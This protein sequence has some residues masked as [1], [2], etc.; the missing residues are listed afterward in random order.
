MTTADVL[1][2]VRA[3]RRG[4]ADRGPAVGVRGHQGGRPAG[5]G[6]PDRAHHFRA[7]AAGHDARGR[8]PGAAPGR[9]AL[10]PDRSQ[11][12]GQGRGGRHP[13]ARRHGGGSRDPRGRLAV[14][15]GDAADAADVALRLGAG[16]PAGRL[17]GARRVRARPAAAGRPEALGPAHRRSGARRRR[18]LRTRSRSGARTDAAAATPDAAR[19]APRAWW[20]RL[21]RSLRLRLRRSGSFDSGRAPA[22]APAVGDT[23]AGARRRRSRPQL[24]RR[25]PC[26]RRPRSR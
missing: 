13:A 6:A 22:P 4:R 7:E 18:P 10:L 21:R 24:R 14:R 19:P 11:G 9:V 5:A 8:H 1:R 23:R 20:I 16:G 26:P 2:S 3:V 12:S 25:R 15:G 17:P